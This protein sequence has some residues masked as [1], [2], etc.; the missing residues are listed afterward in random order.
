MSKRIT[1]MDVAREAGVSK[2]TV[3]YVLNGRGSQARI[4]TTTSERVMD[5]AKSLGYRPNAIARMLVTRRTDTLAV[6]LQS[7]AYFSAWSGFTSELMRGIS[8]AC[9]AEGYDLMLHTKQIRDTDTEADALADGRVDGALV[10]RDSGD[11]TVLRL[12]ERGLPCVQ[13]FTHSKGGDIP[14]VDCENVCGGYLATEHLLSLGHRRIAMVRGSA[15][16]VSSND[17]LVGYRNALA[18]YGVEV[19]PEW[20]V[21]IANPQDDLGAIT[22]LFCPALRPTA[23]V[24]WSDDVAISLMRLLRDHRIAVPDAVSIVGFDSLAAAET[25]VPALTSVRQPVRQM[26]AEATSMLIGLAQGR[27]VSPRQLLFTPT[28][29]IRA[30]TAPPAPPL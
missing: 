26:A 16:S 7:G 3:S 4:S 6:L 27:P 21:E 11:P 19:V 28:L 15:G 20:I 25:A 9:Y 18:E 22:A 29:D 23:L 8:E 1:I 5:A 2:V 10:L 30:S 13:F 17:R 12:I 24:V 14:S